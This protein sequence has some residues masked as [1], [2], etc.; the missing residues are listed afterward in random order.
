MEMYNKTTD[1]ILKIIAYMFGMFILFPNR[2][3]PYL[4]LILFIVSCFLYKKSN[5]KLLL[6]KGLPLFVLF[7]TYLFSLLY[8]SEIG[9]GINLI[10]RIT[11][12][13]ILPYAFSVIGIFDTQMFFSNFKKSFIISYLL[14]CKE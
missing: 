1:F 3:K 7:S 13:V 8:S 2:V 6:N 10:L 4:I 14:L 5:L 12:L 11:P 9:T